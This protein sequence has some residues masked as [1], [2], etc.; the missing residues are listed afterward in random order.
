VF[1]NYVVFSQTQYTTPSSKICTYDASYTVELLNSHDQEITLYS[2]SEIRN[3][4]AL[5]EPEE[6]ETRPREKIMTVL[7][8]TSGLY[9]VKPVSRC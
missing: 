2:L 8:L 3:Q 7:D 9:S 5:E 4:S 1:P 6:P